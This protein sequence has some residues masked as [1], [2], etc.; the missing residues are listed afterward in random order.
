MASMTLKASMA[1][2]L[3]LSQTA[4]AA[5]FP[6]NMYERSEIE[7]MPLEKRGAMSQWQ[8]W[9][10]GEI[11]Y[12]LEG[13]QHD[14]SDNIRDAMRTWEQNTCIRFLPKKD[15]AAWVNFKKYDEGCY[16]QRLGS[17]DKGEVQV[18]FD[19]PN[20]W[21]QMISLGTFK[22][23]SAPGT[24]GQTLGHV[25]GLINEQQRPDRDQFIEVLEN[26]IKKEF[27]DQFTINPDADTSVPFDYN[28]IMLYGRK[29]FAKHNAWTWLV[30]AWSLKDTMKSVTDKRINP[31]DTPTA[32]DYAAVNAGYGCEEYFRRSIPECRAGAIPADGEHS[33]YS[34]L[35]DHWTEKYMRDNG[36]THVAAHQNCRSNTLGQDTNNWG[37]TPLNGSGPNAQYNVTVDRC[38]K[39][40][41]RHA[42][43][44]EVALCRGPDEGTCEVKCGLRRVCPI[45]ANGQQ[46]DSKAINIVDDALWVCHG[47]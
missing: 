9:D 44:Y 13:L 45:D 14:L 28:S 21:E 30:G 31:W 3:A 17:P 38:K 29:A 7:A 40:F 41:D 37:F 11:P 10:K 6:A 8:L 42:S 36:Y 35:L 39:D 34:F 23:C 18:N 19:Y 33:S 4:L 12:I 27:L 47:H 2:A 26:R 46:V 22:G 25:I 1:V 43:R 20:A 24:A 32:N 16:S 15:Q 5:V